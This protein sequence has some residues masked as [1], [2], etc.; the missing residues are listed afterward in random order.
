MLLTVKYFSE[1]EKESKGDSE[2][3]GESYALLAGLFLQL[4]CT[5]IQRADLPALNIATGVIL[6]DRI[7]N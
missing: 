6:H 2:L 7:N 1:R 5:L 4:L 3:K